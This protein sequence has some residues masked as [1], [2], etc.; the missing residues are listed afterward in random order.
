MIKII[1]LSLVFILIFTGGCGIF[2]ENRSGNIDASAIPET[3]AFKDEF[4]REFMASGEEVEEGFYSFE[5][6]TNGY[7]MLFPR[8]AVISKG[9]YEIQE[10]KY[11]T[12]TFGEKLEDKNISYY[13]KLTFEDNSN[14]VDTDIKLRQLSK[15]TGYSGN[16]ESEDMNENTVYYS[17]DK[18]E[19]TDYYFYL[20][21]IKSKQSDKAIR[22]TYF[23][24]C[25]EEEKNCELLSK[26]V[27]EKINSLIESINLK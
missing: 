9:N 27:D 21:Y 17:S 4:T 26:D 1:Q 25:S 10:D 13:I 3:E 20:A 12:L 2:K 5:S 23:S 18:P 24:N 8:N 22:L 15:S 11:E 16:F 7:T 6:K 14:T 19:E